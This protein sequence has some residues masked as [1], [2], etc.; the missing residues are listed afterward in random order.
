[1]EKVLKII[2]LLC[3]LSRLIIAQTEIDNLLSFGFTELPE[4]SVVAECKCELQSRFNI[5]SPDEFHCAWINL[6]SYE[7]DTPVCVLNEFDIK[8]LEL[9]NCSLAELP[10]EK[11]NNYRDLR[12]LI[13]K[14]AELETLNLEGLKLSSLVNLDLSHNKFT[15][16]PNNQF[17]YF[18]NIQ[19]INL[20]NNLIETIEDEA[21]N[22]DPYQYFTIDLS[23]NRIKF[24][25]CKW[26]IKPR[27]YTSY[28]FVNFDHNL[29]E[30]ISSN[31]DVEHLWK[32]NFAFNK[33]T[34]LN[35][36]NFY[37]NFSNFSFNEISEI[38]CNENVEKVTSLYLSNNFL[39]K[40]ENFYNC[41][42][43]LRNLIQLDLSFNNFGSE[44]LLKIETF[45]E[46]MKL[47]ILSLAGNNIS[48][49][50]YG[51]FSYQ[52]KLN[53]LDLSNNQLGNFDIEV[54]ISIENLRTLDLSFN[55]FYSSSKLKD[56][57]NFLPKLSNLG[58]DGNNFQCKCLSFLL[59]SV[60]KQELFIMRPKF[61]IKNHTNINGMKCFYDSEYSASYC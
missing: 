5:Y 37:D 44:P 20:S 6:R 9:Q 15:T 36:N 58:I 35:L 48:F 46:L 47:E 14:N 26:F 31:E 32:A 23:F 16:L 49:I 45:S 29:I 61:F 52:N 54:L 55:Q 19:K 10:I 21:F 38:V 22:L 24:V 1:M 13:V 41:L 42:Q 17:Q 18:K 7:D 57:K 50:P 34:R 27:Q 56:I 30:E 43:K 53:S 59:N 28:S 25:D 33:L 2:L 40:S 51:L 4:V 12:N 39:Q 11:I 60:I 8:L 3:F